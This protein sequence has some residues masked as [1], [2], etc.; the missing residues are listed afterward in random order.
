[1]KKAEAEGQRFAEERWKAPPKECEHSPPF[2]SLRT[3]DDSVSAGQ[4]LVEVNRDAVIGKIASSHG[5][6]GCRPA[7]QV[8]QLDD[9]LGRQRAHSLVTA[10]R[11]K[12]LQPLPVVFSPR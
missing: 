11:H 9:L 2:P 10:P 3:I 6:V 8:A 4:Q 1:M 12:L 5:Q 7:V